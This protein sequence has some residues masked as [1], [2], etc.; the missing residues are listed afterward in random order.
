MPLP[1]GFKKHLDEAESDL[2]DLKNKIKRGQIGM[3]AIQAGAAIIN[4]QLVLAS[5]IMAGAVT[6]ETLNEKRYTDS[7]R[8]GDLG[9]I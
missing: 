8:R 7:V 2:V 5:L 3:E 9:P 1:E 4:A 6:E